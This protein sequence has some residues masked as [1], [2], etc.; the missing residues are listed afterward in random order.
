MKPKKLKM[1]AFGPYKHSE[2]IDFSE[3]L[4][5]RLFVVSGT[6]GAGKTTIFDAICFALYGSASGEDRNDV[7]MLRSDFAEDDTHTSVELEFE[8][9][10][11]IYRILRQLGHVKQGNKGATG[12]RY[13]FNEIVDSNEVPCVDRQIVSEINKKVEELLGLSRDQFSQIVMLPQG[14]FRKL[15]TSQ[16]E[17]KEEI[18]RKI[19]KTE[20]YK[21]I[22]ERFKEKKSLTEEVHKQELQVRERHIHSISSIL[23]KREGSLLTM[24]MSQEHYNTNQ[25]LSGLEEEITYYENKMT[26]DYN[27]Y[28]SSYQKHDI[29]Q[30]EFYNAKA[31]NARFTELE[32]KELKLNSLI[33]QLPLI[34]EK[35][36]KFEKSKRASQIQVY[37]NQLSELLKEEAIKKEKYEKAMTNEKSAFENL[38]K[39]KLR[40]ETEKAKKSEREQINTTLSTLKGY[41]SDVKELTDRKAKINT[42]KKTVEQINEKLVK[43]NKHI[44]KIK[45]EKVA[46]VKEI[47][48]MEQLVNRLPDLQQLRIEMRE[49]Y[50][51]LNDLI[52]LKIK[53]DSVTKSLVIS[54]KNFNNSMQFY[55]KL[56]RNWLSQQAG[57]IASHLHDGNACPVCGSTRHPNKAEVSDSSLSKEKLEAAKTETSRLESIFRTDK[58]EQTALQTQINQKEEEVL[59]FNIPLEDSNET[60]QQ[61][62]IDGKKIKNEIESLQELRNQ[63]NTLK[64]KQNDIDQEIELLLRH[65]ESL[66]EE[67]HSQ[68][69]I[70]ES[71]KAVLN[72]KLKTI[73][74]DVQ[75]LSI[76]ENKILAAEDEKRRL[77]SAWEDAQNHYHTA[78]EA[79]TTS[80]MDVTHSS[81]LI[82]EVTIKKN[83]AE[84]QFVK[85]LEDGQFE[86]KEDYIR[87]KLTDT[88]L[89]TLQE[90][91]N[92]FKQSLNI[93]K[94]QVT[95]LQIELKDKN[96][97]NLGQLEH[98]LNEL[99]TAYESSFKEYNL[100]KELKDDAK[101]LYNSILKS[102]Q[103]L[104]KYEQDLSI[105][106]DLYDA[107]RG[108]NTRKIS[109][110]RYLQIEY[111][112]QIIFAAN[113]RL[114]EMSNG[115]FYLIRSDR[116]ESR[117]RQSG[118]GLDVYDSYTGITRDV[119]TLSGGEKFN[120]SLCLALGMAD[121]IQSF[122]GGISIDTMFIDEGFGSLDEESLLKAIDTLIELQQSGRMI[123]VISH[124]QELKSAIPA[125]LEV[126]KT[127]EGYSQTKF[128]IK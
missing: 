40:Y 30:G 115:Q 74:E 68:K 83:A 46:I 109:F 5:H 120:A 50:K 67:F 12:E 61:L 91:I 22:S 76:L 6:T 41:L 25:I 47:S 9:R 84:S 126:S 93:T 102:N 11:R 122:Q 60:A 101:T 27:Q 55:Q 106:T 53:A 70:L 10:G 26:L 45:A 117:G 37:E 69:S 21:K 96:R 124:V 13:E 85:V 82:D 1:T 39:T 3:L 97:Y 14:E 48:K 24:I 15:L 79:H 62:L 103:E 112:E 43:Q 121:V 18:L 104:T 23:P 16:T 107:I 35:E 7:K 118:L 98:E 51:V 63:L 42:F 72:E 19:F 2:T 57:I 92:S 116:Q 100:S 81:Q 33:K 95:D 77:E 86:S 119:K 20:P 94:Q 113:E 49:K 105:I 87:S 32:E 123:G 65:K 99:K 75:I 127:K 31:T 80:R 4:Q 59:S 108:Q 90:E 128:K 89:N 52:Q 36:E 78:V 28:E 38:Q 125:I 64:N 111:L 54:E 44:E 34:E 17:N 58:A 88:Q 66:E 110:E 73:P 71:S 29:K 114:K 8:L 56:E